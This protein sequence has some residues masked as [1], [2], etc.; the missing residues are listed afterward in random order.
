MR[1][2]LNQRWKQH[3]AAKIIDVADET[4]AWLIRK[5][6]ATPAPVIETASAEP[7]REIATQPRAAKRRPANSAA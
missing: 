5:K 4:G 2:L 6:I 3:Q 1:V 7:D